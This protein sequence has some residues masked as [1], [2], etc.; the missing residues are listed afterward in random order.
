MK[1]RNYFRFSCPLYSKTLIVILVNSSAG[2]W[3]TREFFVLRPLLPNAKVLT[4]KLPSIIPEIHTCKYLLQ[5]HTLS[6][7]RAKSKHEKVLKRS[8][9]KRGEGS[10]NNWW[11]GPDFI[12]ALRKNPLINQLEIFF[13]NLSSPN[14]KIQ[15]KLKFEFSRQNLDF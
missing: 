15:K 5:Q 7:K 9:K 8:H 11:S 1:P 10:R 12:T 2:S 14:L 6:S 4:R 13:K 3:K